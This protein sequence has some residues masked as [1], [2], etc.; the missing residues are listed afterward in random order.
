MVVVD[1]LDEWLD[2]ATLVLAGFGH[3]S[4]HLERVAFD[5]GH[6]SVWEGMLL[7]AIILRLDYDDF[8]AGV[9]TAGDDGLLGRLE[10]WMVQI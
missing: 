2:F 10:R 9:S 8:S 4:G 3:A 6:E 5:A 7:A 1:D